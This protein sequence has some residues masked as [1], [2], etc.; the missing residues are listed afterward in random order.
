M[1]DAETRARELRKQIEDIPASGGG[2]L[3]LY[4]ATLRQKMSTGMFNRIEDLAAAALAEAAAE[5]RE[6]CAK[7]AESLEVLRRAHTRGFVSDHIA[8]A[9]RGQKP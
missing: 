5:E 7:I 4:P 2:A 1:T 9:I 8:A 3:D 6:A